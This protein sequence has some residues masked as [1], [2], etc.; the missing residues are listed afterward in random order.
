MDSKINNEM[1]AVPG[2]VREQIADIVEQAQRDGLQLTGEGGVLPD[3]IKQAVEAALQG[4]MTAHL[5]YEKYAVEGRGS[6][7]SRNGATSK[8][9]Q[10]AAGPAEV[11][12]PRDRQ[13][14][15]EPVTVPKGARRLTEFDD[16]VISLYAKGLTTRDIAEWLAQTYGA[17][18][19]H[20]TIANITDSVNDLVVEWR[21]RP[22]DEVYPIVY[23]DAIRV[24]VRDNGAVRI[25]ACH[26]AVGVDLEGRKR[27]LG[28]W[29]EQ[30]EGAR[31]WLGVLNELRHRGV[32][33][34]LIVCCDGLTGLP[35]VVEQVWPDALVQTCVVHLIRNSM[36]YASW[37]DRKAIAAALRPIY[38]APSVAA[39]EHALDT[40]AASEIGRR[41][42][43]VVDVWRRAWNDLVPF[44]DLPAE[45]R[46]VVY[47]TNAIESINYQLRKVSKTRGQFPSDDAVY[48]MKRPRFDAASL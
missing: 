37:K 30:T 28:L 44:L 42:P 2:E 17:Q 6:G 29:I 36:R 45:I 4:E 3:L 18:L 46:R 31:F 5:G 21:S 11:E 27:V 1:P 26:L 34:V 48:K 14:T 41:C 9:V 35:A 15:F 33:D 39:A 25:K 16:M 23:I 40:F 12:V 22:L 20:E 7:N 47:T 24:R 19:S 38:T 8:T 13:G 43:A 32:R 10:T